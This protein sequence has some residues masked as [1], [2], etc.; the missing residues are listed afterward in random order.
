MIFVRFFD[1]LFYIYRSAQ[2]ERYMA[3]TEIH[4]KAAIE[5]L[6]AIIEDIENDSTDIDNLLVK[7]KRA[8]ELVNY[9]RKKLKSSE[10]EIMR[11]IENIEK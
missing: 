11:M 3:K 10:D 7:V 8:T 5:E 9:C 6:E 4:Y 2:K 1:G